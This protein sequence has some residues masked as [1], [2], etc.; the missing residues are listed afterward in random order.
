MQCTD[1]EKAFDSVEHPALFEVLRRQDVPTHYVDLVK[2]L[3]EKQAAFVQA[4]CASRKFPVARGVK[5]GD[6]ISALLLI[7]VMEDLLGE[8]QAK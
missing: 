1:F 7:A 2:N 8:L 3:Y 4:G 5:Q 6:P